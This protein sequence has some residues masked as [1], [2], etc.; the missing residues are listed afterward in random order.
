MPTVLSRPWSRQRQTRGASKCSV[1]HRR[2]PARPR[3]RRRQRP[4]RVGKRTRDPRS[5]K[6]RA[7]TCLMNPMLRGP[8]NDGFHDAHQRPSAGR[9]EFGCRRQRRL[10]PD[11]LRRRVACPL[12]ETVTSKGLDHDGRLENLVSSGVLCAASARPCAEHTDQSRGGSQSFHLANAFSS[13]GH[14]FSRFRLLAAKI[15]MPSG[16]A[17]R[18]ASMARASFSGGQNPGGRSARTLASSVD[19]LATAV[20]CCSDDALFGCLDELCERLR[21][22]GR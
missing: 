2:R 17:R 20:A 6:S 7:R 22:V 4:V 11:V 8:V 15:T 12:P 21:G 3:S 13:A 18:A 14:S 9:V 19:R 1:G 5:A 10:V 16:L